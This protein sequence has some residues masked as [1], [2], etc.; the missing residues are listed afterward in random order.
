MMNEAKLFML[1]R[2]GSLIEAASAIGINNGSLSI[3]V[4]GH[5][6]PTKYEREILIAALGLHA[7]RKFFGKKRAPKALWL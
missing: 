5:R 6:A 1:K 7:Y 4:H 2:Y 3:L